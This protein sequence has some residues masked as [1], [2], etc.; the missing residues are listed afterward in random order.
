MGVFLSDA[1]GSSGV[2]LPYNASE[3]QRA[4]K[5]S[6][7]TEFHTAKAFA[8]EEPRIE[9]IEAMLKVGLG[10]RRIGIRGTAG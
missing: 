10:D 2:A 3:S 9:L 1:P 4:R 8:R 6:G 5:W 7:V